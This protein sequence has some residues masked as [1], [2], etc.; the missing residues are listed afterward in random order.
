MQGV[1]EIIK[2]S[3][4]CFVAYVNSLSSCVEPAC[5]QVT[6]L[7]FHLPDDH[8]CI[9]FLQVLVSSSCVQPGVYHTAGGTKHRSP[10][11]ATKGNISEV[12]KVFMFNSLHLHKQ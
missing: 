1:A 7:P 11:G 8:Y 4:F 6:F 3:A 9:I 2:V 12:G 10:G 5:V